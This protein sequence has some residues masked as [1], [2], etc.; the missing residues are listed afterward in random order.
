MRTILVTIAFTALTSARLFAQNA[1]TETFIRKGI[2]LH[3]KGDFKGALAQYEKALEIDKKSPLAHYEMASTYFAMK[4]YDNAIEH[5][6]KVLDLKSGNE[7]EAYVLKGTALDVM[8]KPEEAIKTYRK[9]IKQFPQSYLM[10]YNI[11]L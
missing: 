1:E 3:D 10:Q 2:S 9:G 7:E 4:S 6:D 11:A 8:G 5:A